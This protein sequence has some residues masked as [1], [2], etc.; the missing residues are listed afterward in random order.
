M[1]IMKATLALTTVTTPQLHSVPK[2]VDLD[3][4]TALAWLELVAL[5]AEALSGD[6]WLALCDDIDTGELY[7]DWFVWQDQE[8]SGNWEAY[9][10]L[11][12]RRLVA[13]DLAALKAGI[14]QIENARN[15]AIAQLEWNIQED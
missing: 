6:D 9:D 5:D 14:D 2:N 15:S 11:S 3:T 4:C 8:V 10:P 1:K 13:K 7:R 12:D